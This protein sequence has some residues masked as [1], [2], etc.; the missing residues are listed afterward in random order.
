MR[1]NDDFIS[2]MI[3]D[4]ENS[5][6]LATSGDGS[7]TVM[8]LRQRKLEQRSE[9]NESELLSLTIVKASCYINPC[10]REFF[11]N[12]EFATDFLLLFNTGVKFREVASF[13][14]HV[15]YMTA[16]LF[17][18]PEVGSSVTCAVTQAVGS[19]VQ[20]RLLLLCA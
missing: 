15:L 4:G 13:Y 19:T 11:S 20:L 8:D 10:E 3:V 5:T 16:S 1:V 17:S 2:D 12:P 14:I 6:L 9:T 7:L 18:S